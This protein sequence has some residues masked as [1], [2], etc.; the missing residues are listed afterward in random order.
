MSFF[1][2]TM[3]SFAIATLTLT[4]IAQAACNSIEKGGTD[5]N[6]LI[7]VNPDIALGSLTRPDSGTETVTIEPNGTRTL[8]SELNVGTNNPDIF[9]EAQATITGEQNC[10]FQI[11]VESINGDLS[12]VKLAA[13][14]GYSLTS[15]VSGAK[16]TLDVSGRFE[17]TIGVSAT[18]DSAP[19]Q[20]VGG[21]FTVRVTY[22]D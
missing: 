4:D 13:G 6:I 7:T 2:S 10:V 19:T 5:A 16:G 15:N 21:N 3:A 8:P 14:T 12:N 9:N 20:V 17:F 22:S 1:K 11:L 18:I